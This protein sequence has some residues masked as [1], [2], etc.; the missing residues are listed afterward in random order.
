MV[1]MEG[2]SCVVRP[3]Q[4]GWDGY[5]G[6][7]YQEARRLLTGDVN[8]AVEGAIQGG[9][10]EV[11]VD[12]LHGGGGAWNII[13]DLMHPRAIYIRTDHESRLRLSILDDTFDCVF[14][15]AYH[16]MAGNPRAI[17][18]HTFSSR[19]IYRASVN[20]VEV[21]EIAVDSAIAGSLGVPVALV[22][23]CSEA[24][25]E[26]RRFLGSVEAVT[27]KYGL[28][29]TSAYCLPPGRTSDL[30]R[31]ASRRAVENVARSKESLNIFKFGEPVEVM[32]EYMHPN[33]A[34]RMKGMRGVER[35]GS[36]TIIC[37]ADRF[38]D[39]ARMIGWVGYRI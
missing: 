2:A 32:V 33:Y 4:A 23:G 18:S 7:E 38:I 35:V 17:L 5:T 24:V 3:E 34:D 27:V 16:A 12:D 13:P 29:R 10:D 6:V 15:V 20:G 28:A 26:A 9:A 1:D 25:E 36:R 11:Y 8:A 14:L 19:S 30:I 39:A 21:G 31:E 22:T 37:R